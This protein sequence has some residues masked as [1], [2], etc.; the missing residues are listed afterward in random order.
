[1]SNRQLRRKSIIDNAIGEWSEITNNQPFTA[2]DILNS[3]IIDFT[4]NRRIRISLSHISSRLLVLGGKG[5]LEK[6][7][8]PQSQGEI[9]QWRLF[10]EATV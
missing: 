1:M 7:R 3:G 10:G 4:K 6:V 9:I 5:Y 2:I 8:E